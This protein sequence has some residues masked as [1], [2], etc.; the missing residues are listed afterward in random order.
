MLQE[1]LDSIP[2]GI[3]VEVVNNKE[4]NWPLAK[5]WNY[6]VDKY[7]IEK[8]YDAVVISNDD[9][10]FEQD[11]TETLVECLLLRQYRERLPIDRECL[12][13]KAWDKKGRKY[14]HVDELHYG[15]RDWF[16]E[17][18]FCFATSRKLFEEV[19][20]FDE[21]FDP[22]YGEDTDMA[23][24]IYEAGFGAISYPSVWHESGTT[25]RT[26]PER[27]RLVGERVREIEAYFLSKHGELP[28]ADGPRYRRYFYK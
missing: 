21:R 7:C 24:R 17:G 28:N 9:V 13:V 11:T 8:G 2:P 3:E 6:A 1:C 25:T 22:A 27:L 23:Y 14:Y 10:I 15:W 12:V 4:R 16:N 19:G 5:A 20:R 26:D 18:W